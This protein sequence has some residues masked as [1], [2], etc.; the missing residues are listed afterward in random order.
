MKCEAHTGSDQSI[1][2]FVFESKLKMA[3]TFEPLSDSAR[4]KASTS[5]W[6]P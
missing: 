6:Q 3:A 5:P 2:T 4:G 1:K